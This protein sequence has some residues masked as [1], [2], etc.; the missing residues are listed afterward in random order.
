MED[1]DAKKIEFMLIITILPNLFEFLC[2]PNE[3]DGCFFG[4]RV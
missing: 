3:T 1:S 2:I 4:N